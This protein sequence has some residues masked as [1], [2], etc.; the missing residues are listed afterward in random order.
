VTFLITALAVAAVLAV[1]FAIALKVGRHSVIDVAWGLGFVAVA[2][3]GYFL[4]DG[5]PATRL[6]MLVL[7]AVW[8]VRLAVHIGLRARGHGEDPRYVKLLSRATGNRTLYALKTVYLPQGLALWFISLPVQFA[9]REPDGLNWIAWIGVAVWAVG[10]AF[11]A[12]GDWQLT[13]FRAD[14]ANRGRVLDTGLWRYTRHP[15]YFGDA[16]VWWGIFLV[17][18]AH[19][20]GCLTVL[21]PLLMTY[22][23][24]KVTGK[25][26]LERQ[27]GEKPGYAEYIRS[28]SGFIPLPPR[29]P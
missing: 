22:T 19:F 9:Q 17:A 4:F 21:S 11:E 15:N 5:D 27:L 18:A 2:V 13:R 16:C 8:G 6:L 14:P 28:T 29:S 26:V 3:V 25:P 1:T 23:L 12:I 7:V 10:F 20:P 24:M